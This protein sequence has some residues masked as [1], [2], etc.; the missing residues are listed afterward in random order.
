VPGFALGLLLL[1]AVFAVALAIMPGS[2]HQALLLH[3]LGLGLVLQQTAE[4]GLAYGIL[5]A[6]LMFAVA[7]ILVNQARRRFRAHG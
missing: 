3:A 5:A 1:N 4:Y 7:I 6:V 2:R